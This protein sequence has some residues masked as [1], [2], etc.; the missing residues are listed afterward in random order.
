MLFGVSECDDPNTQTAERPLRKPL[1]NHRSILGRF[2]RVDD[3]TLFVTQAL[4]LATPVARGAIPIA[5]VGKR[6]R[7]E[8]GPAR[9]VGAIGWVAL[10]TELVMRGAVARLV[11]E[12]R[13]QFK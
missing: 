10:D 13:R 1:E 3:G 9:F 5:G 7:K 12:G 6:I 4:P 11:V 8:V 2:S